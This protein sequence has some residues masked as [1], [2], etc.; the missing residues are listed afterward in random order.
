MVGL[1]HR[2]L[3]YLY[4]GLFNQPQPKRLGPI[5]LR[6]K[7][8]EETS[9]VLSREP[10]GAYMDL[11][12]LPLRY[13]TFINNILMWRSHRS[14]GFLASQ[15][16]F[17]NCD[18]ASG[19]LMKS[20]VSSLQMSL[21]LAKHCLFDREKEEKKEKEKRPVFAKENGARLYH[22]HELCVCLTIKKNLYYTIPNEHNN[23]KL[24]RAC[25]SKGRRE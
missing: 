14:P 7:E 3:K 25:A 5:T 19:R 1:E 17:W 12:R 4:K 18:D 6:S 16:V 21:Q 9:T 15:E 10:Y 8:R 24:P 23:H 2:G 11:G 22:F 13:R 20:S